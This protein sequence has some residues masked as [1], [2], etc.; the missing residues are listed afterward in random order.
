MRAVTI[1]AVAGSALLAGVAA[2]AAADMPV[3][4]PPLAP[5]PAFSWTGFYVGANVGGAWSQGGSDAYTGPLFPGFIVL[6]PVA[7]VPTLVPGLIDTLPGAGTT[8]GFIGGV[9]A[10]YNWQVKQF[11]F[12][13]EVDASGTDLKGS[14]ASAS[15]TLGA[16]LFAPPVTQ[17]VTVDFGRIDWMASFRGRLG[18]AVDRALFYVTGGAAVAEI[19]GARTTVTNGP[20]IAIAAGSFSSTS[21][22][23]TTRWGWTVGGGIEWAFN[24][25]WSVAGEYR[26]T[27]FGSRGTTFVIPDGIGGTVA[28]ATTNARLTVD[29]VTAR[30]NYRFGGPVVAKY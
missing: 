30:L 3:K 12:G 8:S 29:Q 14:T 20:G 28:T 24:N 1:A 19:G 22:G 4:A 7:A 17:T 9:Q 6:P 15:R 27:D 23:S 25:N 21:G 18:L 2:A 11:V 16:P 26:H 5:A 10:G 13:V